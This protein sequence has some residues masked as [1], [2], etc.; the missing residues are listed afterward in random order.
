[1]T[2]A[3]LV[4]Q[5]L[6]GLQ[7]AMLLFLLAVGLSIVFGLMNFINLAHGTLYMVGAFVGLPRRCTP[8]RSGRRS[9]R[10]RRRRRRSARCFM[11]CCCVACR[12][13]AR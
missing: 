11:R 7:F 13:R 3:S 5:L 10:V 6:N 12:A 1:M 4:F 9:P 2:L 8:A